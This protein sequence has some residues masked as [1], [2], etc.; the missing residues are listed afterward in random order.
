MPL[1]K[2]Y[3]VFILVKSVLY[4]YISCFLLEMGVYLCHKNKKYERIG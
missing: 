4:L 2:P 1:I 3:L